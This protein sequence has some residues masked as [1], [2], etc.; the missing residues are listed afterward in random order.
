MRIC[1]I[2]TPT[3]LLLVAILACCWNFRLLAED[4]PA[5]SVKPTAEAVE[6]F[7]SKIRPLLHA[8][9]IEC[10]NDE[11]A[12]S[13]LSLESQAGLLRGGK[14]GPAVA[15]GKPKESLLISAVNHDEFL[16]M[17]PK[18]KLATADLVLLSKWVSMGAPWPEAS[19]SLDSSKPLAKGNPNPMPE[20]E[21]AGF[22]EKQ[23]SFWSYQPLRMPPVP[24]D[25]LARDS[26]AGSPIQ[27][28]I[29]SPIDAFVLDKLLEKGLQPAP[30]ASRRDWIRRATYDL[31]GL[32]PS[33]EETQRFVENDS[34]DAR[35]RA[36]DRLLA[37]PRYGERWGRHWLDVARFAD[38][39][40]LDE[41]IAYANAFRYRDYVIDSM[42]A[43]K[44]YDRFVQ[45]QIAGDLLKHDPNNSTRDPFD[46]FVA[47]GFLAIG[48]KMLAEDDPVKMQMDII[49]EQLSTLCQ[50]FMG[51]TIGCAR[52]H[53]H[54]FDP[55]P[56]A[57][58]YAL[59]GIFKSS[60]TMENHRVVAKWFERPLATDQELETIRAIDR[61]IDVSKVSQN[62]LN[63]ECRGRVAKEIQACTASALMAT[64]QYDQFSELADKSIKGGLNQTDSPYKVSAGYALIEAEGFNRGT[65]IR[66]TENYG[67]DIGV[68]ISTGRANAEY[69]LEVEHDGS[70]AIEL[71]YTSDERRPIKVSLDGKEVAPAVAAETTGSWQPD[72]QSWFV[73]TVVKLPAGKHVLRFESRRTFPHIDKFALVFQSDKEWPFGT[74]PVALSRTGLDF[75][76]SYPILSLWRTY[77]SDIRSKRIEEGADDSLGALWLRFRDLKDDFQT[78]SNSIY[79]E[80]ESEGTLRQKTPVILR[81]ALLAARPATLKQVASVFQDAVL[82]MA[83]GKADKDPFGKGSPLAGPEIGR[84][85]V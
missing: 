18:E 66:D 78:A 35:M 41:N 32:P 34:P 39:N 83:S 45:E 29:Q 57:D 56:A 16:K 67:K 17:P 73:A 38:S 60:Q 30:S 3:R 68:I 59:A 6:F 4:P 7:E 80:L 64:V 27:S 1:A 62:K 43:D 2:Y 22:T 20:K 23:K 49:D 46:R 69:D 48:A 54:K 14:L 15:P 50:A 42:N 25:L 55:L 84:A 13:G 19:K 37:S 47:T 21:A 26:L 11:E 12:E 61:E 70:Y 82:K 51:I 5:D 24:L 65:V 36:I 63:D 79:S 76:I 10:H 44:S 81:D 52:C 85:H 33:E 28:L 58:Y 8:R 74:E 77:F 40:G 75:G 31:T 9:C 72:G 71:R 53:D